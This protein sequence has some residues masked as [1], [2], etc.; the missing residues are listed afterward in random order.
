MTLGGFG[1]ALL[2]YGEV[3]DNSKVLFIGQTTVAAGI[4]LATYSLWLYMR[5]ASMIHHQVNRSFH[6]PFGPTAYTLALLIVLGLT[7]AYHTTPISFV[8]TRE[9][10]Y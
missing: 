10:G 9:E 4:C 2:V 5:R 3:H 6:D 7:L 1:M 8:Q